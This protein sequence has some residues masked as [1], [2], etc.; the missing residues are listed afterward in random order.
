MHRNT[1]V[2]APRLLDDHLR[3]T[4]E[5]AAKLDAPVYIAGQLAGTEGYCEA[6]R[7]GLHVAFAV[8][9]DLRGQPLP[10]VPEETVFGS[11]LS[12]ATV[13]NT[14]DYQPMHVN[15]GILPPLETRIR[16]KKDR[17][18]HTPNV[19]R[20]LFRRIVRSFVACGLVSN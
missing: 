12:Y 11:L 10:S 8:A 17:Y 4:T 20:G 5:A 14:V 16:N 2:D 3:L 19:P 15:F 13:P 7:S 1:F 6:V 9:A 18:G